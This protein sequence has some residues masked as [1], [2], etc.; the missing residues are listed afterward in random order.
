MKSWRENPE[1]EENQKA[2][3]NHEREVFALN[4]MEKIAREK[5]QK[6][7][8]LADHCHACGMFTSQCECWDAV[9]GEN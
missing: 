4:M 6:Q 3:K 5:Y 9:N 1:S 8:S 2:S 7:R